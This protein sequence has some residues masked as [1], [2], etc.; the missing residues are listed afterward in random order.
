MCKYMP[1]FIID[2]WNNTF[3]GFSLFSVISCIEFV[4]TIISLY[5]IGCVDKNIATT[6]EIMRAE[7]EIQQAISAIK[8]TLKNV[9]LD[10]SMQEA[11]VY[12]NNIY[13]TLCSV[14]ERLDVLKKTSEHE[15][16]DEFLK[17]WALFYTNPTNS[18]YTVENCIRDLT[19]IQHDLERLL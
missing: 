11:T 4:L 1:Q 16:I 18:D 2:I 19:K 13:Q 8:K 17:N 10:S 15:S 5:K 14:S 6:K 3:I 12:V 7:P 9:K